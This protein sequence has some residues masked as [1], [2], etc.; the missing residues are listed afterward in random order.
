ME[1]CLRVPKEVSQILRHLSEGSKERAVIKSKKER[2]IKTLSEEDSNDVAVENSENEI[3]NVGGLKEI[4][5][6]K[7]K[8]VMKESH[9]ISWRSTKSH[10]RDVGHSK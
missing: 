3:E 5:R 10:T 1:G 2:L 4:E 6:R 7:L 9:E 8:Q